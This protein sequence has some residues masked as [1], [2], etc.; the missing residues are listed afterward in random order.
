MT[1]EEYIDK[2]KRISEQQ[3]KRAT[4]IESAYQAYLHGE[5]SE[6]L[7]TLFTN[8][9]T[10]CVQWIRKKLY[11]ANAYSQEFEED[12]LQESK[13]G[14]WNAIRNTSNAPT[15]EVFI[16]YAFTIYKNKTLN[17]IKNFFKDSTHID[18][19]T[20]DKEN[21]QMRKLENAK[22]I[23]SAEENAQLKERKQLYTNIFQAYCHAMVNATSAT[24]YLPRNLALYYA[25]VLPHMQ[26]A[27]KDA[28]KASAK[29]AYEKMKGR[30]IGYLKQDSEQSMQ[31]YFAA[32]ILWCDVFCRQLEEASDLQGD[33][34]PLKDIIYTVVYDK[35]KIED[36][37]DSA[38][39]S[40]VKETI[41]LIEE[42]PNLFQ[43][44]RA[45]IEDGDQFLGR[46]LE[47]KKRK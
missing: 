45:Y 11:L 5:T 44:I 19:P 18:T 25:R 39:N 41:K 37:A 20:P 26:A 28:K 6:S 15:Q 10:Y 8:L 33:K 42:N 16:R 46:I 36:W 24:S 22:T 23:P 43:A 47:R 21:D 34:R 27:I 12:I 1:Q 40:T 29:W 30:T 14:V 17:T 35:A 31:R 4:V 13:C 3:K 38:H 7:N 9:D 2:V 32:M